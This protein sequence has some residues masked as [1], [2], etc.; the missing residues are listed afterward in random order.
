MRMN[1][2]NRVALTLFSAA[3]VASGAASAAQI[4]EVRFGVEAS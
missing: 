4:K 1:W 3:A 2:P